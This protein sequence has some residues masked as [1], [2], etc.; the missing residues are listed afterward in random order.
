MKDWKLRLS[1]NQGLL[2]AIGFFILSYGLYS[3]L[4]PRGFSASLFGQ[5]ANESFVLVMAAMAQTVPVLTGGLDL[6]VG[7]VTTLVDCVA[8]RTLSG[9][10]G[11]IALGVFCCLAVGTLCGLVNGCLVVYGRLQPIIATLASGTIFLG[12]ALFLRPTPGGQV[13]GDLS[14]AMTFDVGEL[15]R[16]MHAGSLADSLGPIGKIPS[17]LLWLVVMALIWT[18]FRATP[19]GLGVYAIGSSQEA[20]YMSGVRL[21][22]VKLSA[23][24]LAG[25]FAGVGGLYLAFQTSSG[26]ADIPQAGAYTLNSIAAV[27]IGGT[28]LYGGVGGAVGSIFGALVLR[29]VAFNFRVFDEGSALGFLSN[30]LYQPLFE[31]IILLTA[32][33]AG[34]AWVLRVKNR[35]EVFR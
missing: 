6:S 35:L 34:A 11:Q 31:G 8:S 18:Y 12:I 29:S 14:A 23:Y 27:V 13:D 30:P 16:T 1:Q 17:P 25:F 10:A 5:N 2:V 9:S 4:H 3:F 21:K 33:C 32:V 28:S 7:P 15:L 24:M 22:K 20:A 26:N 19:Y